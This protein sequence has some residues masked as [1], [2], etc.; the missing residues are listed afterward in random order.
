MRNLFFVF[1]LSLALIA[2]IH[3]TSTYAPNSSVLV[4]D[5]PPSVQEEKSEQLIFT[6]IC[7][8]GPDSDNDGV[9]DWYDKCPFESERYNG[10][11]DANGCPDSA[12]IDFYEERPEIKQRI[13]FAWGSAELSPGADSDNIDQYETIVASIVGRLQ[14]FRKKIVLVE[15]SGHACDDEPDKTSLSERRA[16]RV[17]CRLTRHGVAKERLITRGYGAERPIETNSDKGECQNNGRV[18]FKVLKYQN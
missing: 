11:D 10:A 5:S 13:N 8:P 17:R 1:S 3:H 16:E 7:E 12:Y 15:I 14:K 4:K 9:P 6:S 18:D 2:C